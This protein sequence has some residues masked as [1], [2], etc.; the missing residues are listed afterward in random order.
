[1]D[2]SFIAPVCDV[3]D[4]IPSIPPFQSA[5]LTWAIGTDCAPFMP[6][7]QIPPN[8]LTPT[9]PGTGLPFPIPKRIWTINV[10]SDGKGKL[11]YAHL[12]EHSRGVTLFI[13]SHVFHAPVSTLML[14]GAVVLAVAFGVVTFLIRCRCR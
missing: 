8:P 10:G 7:Q 13:K 1:M 3:G 5:T 12:V 4:P 2:A 11:E 9:W 14:G 6:V